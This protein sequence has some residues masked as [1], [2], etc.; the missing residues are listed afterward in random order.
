MK[1]YNYFNETITTDDARLCEHKFD[2]IEYMTTRHNDIAFTRIENG[3]KFRIDNKIFQAKVT[4]FKNDTNI[5]LM[6]NKEFDIP[7]RTIRVTNVP[8][9]KYRVNINDLELYYVFK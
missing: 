5:I 3:V 6:C 4:R 1:T 9:T 2:I 8:S 7:D